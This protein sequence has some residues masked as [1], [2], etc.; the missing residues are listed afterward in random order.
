MNNGNTTLIVGHHTKLDIRLKIDEDT[1]PATLLFGKPAEEIDSKINDLEALLGK[2]RAG[3]E[4]VKALN[5][6]LTETRNELRKADKSLTLQHGFLKNEE[7][8]EK[9]GKL[10]LY[11]YLAQQMTAARSIMAFV[12]DRYRQNDSEGSIGQ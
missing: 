9:Q 12:A 5:K 10:G 6:A 11:R 1:G 8:F 7:A 2:L 3:D 4:L